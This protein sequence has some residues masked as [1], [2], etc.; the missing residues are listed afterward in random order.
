ML[1][2]NKVVEYINQDFVVMQDVVQYKYIYLD[3]RRVKKRLSRFRRRKKR[4]NLLYISSIRLMK[5]VRVNQ[6]MII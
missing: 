3:D 5:K 6:S 2:V 1:M 4:R